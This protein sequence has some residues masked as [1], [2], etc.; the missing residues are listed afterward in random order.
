MTFIMS[1]AAPTPPPGV[2]NEDQNALLFSVL[3]VECAISIAFV[4]TRMIVR[5]RVIKNL[6]WDDWTICFTMVSSLLVGSD[7]N[8]ADI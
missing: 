4:A 3:W 8:K 5:G 1:A 6:W 2:P 7:V